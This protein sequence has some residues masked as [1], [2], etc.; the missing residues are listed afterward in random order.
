MFETTE[1]FLNSNFFV[2]LTTL[3]TAIV[4]LCLYLIAEWRKKRDAAKMIIQEIRRSEQVIENLKLSE[5]F[6]LGEKIIITNS[7]STNM[8]F[9]VD[10][11][12]IDELDKIYHLYAIS[13]YLDTILGS[14]AHKRAFAEDEA[15][16]QKIN[17][18]HWS[19]QVQG[20]INKYQPIY[21]STI[22]AKLKKIAG[23]K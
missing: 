23:E 22:C 18:Q 7:W 4:A 21:N 1:S 8:H 15:E 3:L 2:G 12:N 13:E 10:Q 6:V 14:V 5:V 19:Q 11:L 9:F 17:K 20:I 16:L